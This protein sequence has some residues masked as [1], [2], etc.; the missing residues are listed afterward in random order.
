MLKKELVSSWIV[1]YSCT[2][3]LEHRRTCFGGMKRNNRFTCLSSSWYFPTRFLHR[4]AVRGC[5]QVVSRGLSLFSKSNP[6]R[7]LTP[8]S[9]SVSAEVEAS[10]SGSAWVSGLELCDGA[11]EMAGALSSSGSG[12]ESGLPKRNV[13]DIA[14]H[15]HWLICPQDLPRQ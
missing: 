3:L 10:A 7:S 5:V 12:C 9:M 15:D 14:F 6:A 13:H 2:H 11:L 4:L 8:V 1:T